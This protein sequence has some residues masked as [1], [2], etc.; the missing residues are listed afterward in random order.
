MGGMMSVRYRITYVCLLLSLTGCLG[1]ARTEDLLHAR[2]RAQ[3]DQLLQAKSELDEV[4]TALAKSRRETSQLRT[5]LAQAEAGGLKTASGSGVT[6]VS[7]IKINSMLTAGMDKNDRKGDDTLVVNFAPYDDDG[8][9]VKLHGTVDIVAMDPRLPEG[10]QVVARWS[11]A[12]EET[13][14]HWVRGFLGSGYQF[15][16]PWP[17]PPQHDEVVLHVRLRAPDEREFVATQVVKI[18]PEVITAAEES[19]TEVRRPIREDEVE[20]MTPGPSRRTE[21]R[22][23]TNWTDTT[24]PIR[25]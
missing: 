3:Q 17:K 25:R 6:L 10:E 8:E 23:S 7:A 12:P 15:S 24:M 14:E 9:M 2:L 18:Q 4:T 13:R 22:E 16:L 20:I 1:S 19:T 21:I 5:A 11:F